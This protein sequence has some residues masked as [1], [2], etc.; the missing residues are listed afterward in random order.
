[1]TDPKPPEIP[2]ASAA[3]PGSEQ[4]KTL[5][6]E[7]AD[8]KKRVD[9]LSKQLDALKKAAAQEK[10]KSKATELVKR[11][12]LKGRT[13]ANDTEREVEIERLAAL[14]DEALA[15]VEITVSA[16]PDL[17]AQA[18]RQPILKTDAGVK[19]VNVADTAPGDE[20][21]TGLK[22]GL[23]AAYKQNRGEAVTN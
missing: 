6:L 17:S 1:M 22:D 20:L 10:A 21:K 3:A 12:E 8:L 4:I 14:S 16:M 13:F 7:N 11:F 23:M 5:E 15:A 19:P 9:E 2:P 18:N